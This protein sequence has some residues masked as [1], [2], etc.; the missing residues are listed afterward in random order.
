MASTEE[1]GKSMVDAASHTKKK[2]PGSM[3][4]KASIISKD[5][6]KRR[7]GDGDTGAKPMHRVDKSKGMMDKIQLMNLL[8]NSSKEN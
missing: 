4:G 2:K 3:I 6:I 8:R 5:A 7:M 1:I